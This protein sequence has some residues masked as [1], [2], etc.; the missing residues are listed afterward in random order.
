LKP[1]AAEIDKK[2][3][4]PKEQIKK[5]GDLGL[6]GLC[7]PEALGGTGLDTLAYAIAME[8]ISRGCAAAGVIMSVQNSL[9]LGPIDK[10]GT[11]KQKEKYITPFVTGEKIGCFALSEPGNGSDAGAASTTAKA[12]GNAYT[13]N[14][15]KS[16]IT[17]AYEA[18]AIVLF[19]T[20]D[21]SKKHKGISAF[22]VDSPTTG[23]SVGKKEDKLG[24]RGSSTCSLIFEDCQVPRDNV[25][26]EPGMGFKIAMMTLGMRIKMHL[27]FKTIILM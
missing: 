19:A 8:E 18:K 2:H 25:L 11:D 1:I 13:I 17:N 22:I 16:W 14:G 3:L 5:M 10:F 4:F 9:Y 15:T 6:M 12:D 27:N 26:S 21:K 7:I 23:L 24:I 20:T